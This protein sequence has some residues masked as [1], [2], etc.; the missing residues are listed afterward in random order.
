LS[1]CA[2]IQ[3]PK[4]TVCR[5][6][7]LLDQGVGARFQGEGNIMSAASFCMMHGYKTTRPRE[8]MMA[9]SAA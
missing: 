4:R 3:R 6:L 7:E 5:K 1:R 9:A 8:A 2:C